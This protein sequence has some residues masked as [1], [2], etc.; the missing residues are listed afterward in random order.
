MTALN[1]APDSKSEFRDL[2][3]AADPEDD[4]EIPYANFVAVAALKINAQGADDRRQEIE[5]AFQLFLS[6][7]GSGLAGRAAQEE[8]KINY[9]TLKRVAALLKDEIKE[10]ALR[11]MILEANGGAGV[12]KGVTLDEFEEVMKRGRGIPLTLIY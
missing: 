10:D 9:A 8:G 5:D 11:D 1:I 6:M 3:S 7:G 4:G 12:E 2:L